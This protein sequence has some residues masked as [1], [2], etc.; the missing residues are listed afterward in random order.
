MLLMPFV[1]KVY[2]QTACD[3]FK[4]SEQ[5]RD[6]LP[7]GENKNILI[8]I[9]LYWSKRCAC[10]SGAITGGTWDYTVEIGNRVYDN[11]T[12]G[13]LKKKLE[14]YKG[15]SFPAP[16]KRMSVNDC[17]KDDNFNI[18]IDASDCLNNKF[19]ANKDPQ[20]FGNA[21]LLAK[22]ECEKG[23]PTEQRAKELEATMKLNYQ[24]AKTYYGN[25]FVLPQPLAYTSCPIIE[26]GGV[27][28]NTIKSEK[29]TLY[30]SDLLSNQT[31]T[32]IHQ[33]AANS[34]NPN[35]KQ[36]SM[37]LEHLDFTQAQVENYRSTF[38]LSST[39]VDMEFDQA[40]QNIGQGIA[41]AKYIFGTLRNN[42]E[43]KELTADEKKALIFMQSER[44]QFVDLHNELKYSSEKK[45]YWGKVS[46]NKIEEIENAYNEFELITAKKRWF[47]ISYFFSKNYYS[48]PEL[49]NKM[50]SINSMSD[51]QVLEKI[52]EWQ[53]RANFSSKFDYTVFANNDIAFK[54]NMEL[55]KLNKL[56]YYKEK[57]MQKEY[58]ALLSTLNFN[59]PILVGNAIQDAL[60]RGDYNNIDF[61]VP[62]MKYYIEN[63]KS[64]YT[65]KSYYSD[66]SLFR[67][68]VIDFIAIATFKSI[69]DNELMKAQNEIDYMTGLISNINDNDISNRNKENSVY[70]ALKAYLQ[71]KLNDDPFIHLAKIEEAIIES[72]DGVI[73]GIDIW[74]QYVNFKALAACH[75]HDNALDLYDK[76]TNSFVF[77]T[78]SSN[79]NGTIKKEQMIY[80]KILILIDMKELER[81]ENGIKILKSLNFS[82]EKSTELEQLIKLK[83]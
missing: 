18:N 14:K 21:F 74:L 83:K 73:E 82:Q 45:I 60:I 23:V 51:Q 28:S 50:A 78:G 39:Q 2:A 38:N 55:L 40:M 42:N 54:E 24:N 66:L 57:G 31:Q 17:K 1:S 58:D 30:N 72:K 77:T 62:Q 3:N 32:I 25:S 43:T 27:Q 63:D 80:D 4:K 52:K 81:A 29:Q 7:L 10:E 12:N 46:W 48:F 56:S 61:L 8:Q 22:C 53:S 70:K 37:D 9:V 41:L 5:I 64:S 67:H 35:L 44:D 65:T 26:F 34:S 15:P 76:I 19:D 47:I 13:T 6:G 33:L 16:D 69:E 79:L 68:Q 71:I 75:K 59:S 11:Y 49:E 36:L 20:Q